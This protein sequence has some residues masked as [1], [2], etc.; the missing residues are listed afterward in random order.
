MLLAEGDVCGP[1]IPSQRFS[2]NDGC[3]LCWLIGRLSISIGLFRDLSC[4]R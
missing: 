1:K 2:L 3:F 4:A